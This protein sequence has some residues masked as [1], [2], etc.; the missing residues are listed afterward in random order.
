MQMTE[1]VKKFFPVLFILIA[2]CMPE[3]AMA[4]GVD[5]GESSMSSINDW[6]MT[7]IPVAATV[8]I[9]VCAIG[10]IAHVIRADFA[11]RVVVGLI[12]CGSASY[13]V[14]LFGLS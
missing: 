9:V 8:L 1:V 4:A 2:A 13:L 6:L 3:L 11:I 14:G 10:W 7:W 5:T 12:V